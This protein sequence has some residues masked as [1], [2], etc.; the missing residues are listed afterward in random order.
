MQPQQLGRL[1]VSK[2][3]ESDPSG[4]PMAMVFPD[5]TPADLERLAG[6]CPLPDLTNDPATT[7]MA[8]SMHSFVLQVDGQ[9]ILIDACNGNCKERVVP[10]VHNLQTPY[11]ENLAAAGFQPE[12]IHLVMCTHLHF[13][14]VGW[15]TRL[16]NGRW[17]PTFP[18]ARY[19]FGKRDH[20]H[21][22]TEEVEEEF[23]HRQ[24]YEDS[25]LPVV[26]A[27]QADI[28]DVDDPV[29][30]HREI[31]EGV[32]MEPAFGHS[33]GCVLIK[34]QAGGASALFWGDVIH[35]P[36]Q[37][38]RPEIALP[39]DFD[40]AAAVRVRQAM[41]ADIADADTT[42][43]PAH[44]GGASAGHVHRDGSAYRYQFVEG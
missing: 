7:P 10:M 20:D 22:S 2:V 26:Q 36:V 21:R 8:L 41:L 33:P 23:V 30:V 14:H 5:I 11:L 9:N 12:D 6:W 38:I 37:M 31:G 24:A 1:R 4:P 35:H 44:F 29:A 19:V 34:A 13:D 42:C 3:V 40:P 43:F 28:I 27:G 25:V 16:E 32:W 18:N 15:N 17:V 39:F